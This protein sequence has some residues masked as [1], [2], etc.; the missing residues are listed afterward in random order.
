MVFVGAYFDALTYLEDSLHCGQT[1]FFVFHSFEELGDQFQV[2][3]LAGKFKLG[4]SKLGNVL[5]YGFP[6]E[7][8]GIYRSCNEQFFAESSS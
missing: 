3:Q 2:R 7:G 6:D 1:C 4:R 5:V 8:L